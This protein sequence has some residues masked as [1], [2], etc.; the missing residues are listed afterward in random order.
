MASFNTPTASV[1]C[2]QVEK[3]SAC[4]LILSVNHHKTGQE[5]LKRGWLFPEKILIYV[6]FTAYRTKKE[7]RSRVCLVRFL[8]SVSG[9]T[10][11]GLA[12]PTIPEVSSLTPPTSHALWVGWRLSRNACRYYSPRSCDVSSRSLTRLPVWW[13]L[14][15]HLFTVGSHFLLRR[16]TC[17]CEENVVLQ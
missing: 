13:Q 5:N 1:N 12:S 10:P 7:F 11:E 3:H 4:V 6:T 9:V 16:C 14:P 15:T 8:L 17:S 2:F